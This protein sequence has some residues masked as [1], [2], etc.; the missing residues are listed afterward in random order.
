MRCL[1]L[2]VFLAFVVH[3]FPSGSVSQPPP[4][5]F[6]NPL[7]LA[8][9]ADGQRA[10]VALQAAGS[11]AV[12]DLREGKAL[13]EIAVG[14][15]PCDVAMHG[16][17]LFVSCEDDDCVMQIEL[18][19]NS[20]TKRWPVNQAP[21]G[22]VFDPDGNRLFVACHDAQTIQTLELKSGKTSAL[23]VDAWPERVIIHRGLLTSNLLILATNEKSTVV[24]MAT[25]GASPRIVTTHR[26]ANVSNARGIASKPGV[27]PYVL[28]PHQNPRDHVPATQV[29]QGWVFVNAVSTLAPWDI[30]PP[31]EL[32]VL[33]KAL[34]EPGRAHAEPSDVLFSADGKLAFVACAGADSVLVLRADR[35]ASAKAGAP[36]DATED[37]GN[38][39]V[40]NTDLSLSRRHIITRIP[41][42]AN[43]RRLALSGDG[44]T[45]V[46]SNTLADSL[47]VIDARTFQVHRHIALGDAKPDAARRGEILFHSGRMT[48]LGQFSCASCHPGGGA[49][50]LNWD[51]SRDGIGN[52]LNTRS[53]RGVADTAPYGWH[54]TSPTL[55]DRIAGTLRLTHRHE[56]IGTEVD[57]LTA[58]LRT[59]APLRPLPMSDA[60]RAAGNRGKLLFEGKAQCNACHQGVTFSD[61]LTH[62]V[63]TKSN[64][65]VA[66]RFDTPSLRG[67]ART[68]PYLHHGQAA[69]LEEIFTKFNERQRHGAAH[70]LTPREREDLL[71][72][73]RGL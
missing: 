43:P 45:L 22:M 53:L 41:T 23:V 66:D 42:Q 52:F 58:Y 21:R 26:L 44:N 68:A 61:T 67:V 39:S 37:D 9:D 10:Y 17:H 5:G 20:I 6:K 8:V 11:V 18:D 29:A 19:T 63:G 15:T 38:H 14:K 31:K 54:G 33:T 16:R 34:D 48:F 55:A 27:S 35:L 57:D 32:T 25:T 4:F 69:T 28:V 65:D 56:P 40:R 3:A 46:V 7:G 30:D 64:G 70:L 50:G 73:V 49:D 59:L 1:V 62:D 71:A 60:Q 36:V 24:S 47:T 51:L 72:Y 2:I 13:R 12:V